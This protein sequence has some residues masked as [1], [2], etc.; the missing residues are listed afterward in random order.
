[1][2]KKIIQRD[3]EQL[4]HF[5]NQVRDL[6]IQGSVLIIPYGEAMI[7][8]YYQEALADLSKFPE[9]VYVGIQTNLS[10]SVKK[11]L[12][13]LK[14]HDG[15]IKK[16]RLW[17]T[18]HPESVSFDEFVGKCNELYHADFSFCI[19]CVGV[20]EYLDMIRKLRRQ[21]PRECYLWINR[22][23]GMGRH[24]TNQEIHDFLEIDPCFKQELRLIQINT[25][26]CVGNYFISGDGSVYPCPLNRNTI[27]NFYHCSC[28]EE[29]KACDMTRTCN[30]PYCRCYL[31]YNN[32]KPPKELVFGEYP[33]FRIPDF[34][35]MDSKEVED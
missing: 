29:L 21:L 9:L 12:S 20:P 32:I 24:Y 31:A 23:D 13:V 30:S 22:M 19:G 2:R 11:F 14:E 6:S 33:A 16:I 18:F 27:G 7:H 25:S 15:N 5:V 28:Q 10:F 35:Y 1:M 4:Q 34:S 3:R 17:A 26:A 8:P